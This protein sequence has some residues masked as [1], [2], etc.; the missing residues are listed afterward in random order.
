MQLI[1][2]FDSPFVRRVAI[3]MKLLELP[4]THRNWSVGKDQDEI[5]RYNPLGRVPTLVLNDGTALADSAAIL[6]YLDQIVG[7]AKALLPTSG[8]QR[9]DA[10]QLMALATGAAE[11]GVSQLYEGIFRPEEKQHAPWLSRCAEQMHGSLQLLDQ[12]CAQGANWLVQPHMTQA[13]ITVTTA[14]SFLQDAFAFEPARYGALH[15]LAQRC[16]ALP[17]FQ[18]TRIAFFKPQPKT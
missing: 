1:G 4:F 9:R 5:R 15:A 2:M 12:H 8:S 6:D 3:S 10:L 18:E 16:E 7:P 11:K 14:Y 13:D 17:A